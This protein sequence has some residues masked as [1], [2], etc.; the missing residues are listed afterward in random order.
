MSAFP[1]D[2]PGDVPGYVYF[3]WRRRGGIKIGSSR[4]WPSKRIS[5]TSGLSSKDLLF[6][7]YTHSCRDLERLLHQRLKHWRFERR[8]AWDVFDLDVA[9]LIRFVDGFTDFT[10][11]GIAT[12][13]VVMPFFDEFTQAEALANFSPQAAVKSAPPPPQ[14]ATSSGLVQLTFRLPDEV[15]RQIET[16]AR[17]AGVTKEDM[18]RWIVLQG[19]QAWKR[20]ERPELEEIVR[21]AARLEW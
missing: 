8:G 6:A 10:F 1:N 18:K 12:T 3:V 5:E 20:G 17:E 19:V 16:M 11:R 9:A 21:R 4:N 14:L 15:V 7:V 13:L 2:P